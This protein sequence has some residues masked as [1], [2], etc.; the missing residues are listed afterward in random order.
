MARGQHLRCAEYRAAAVEVRFCRDA[1]E[2][3]HLPRSR[4]SMIGEPPTIAARARREC[5]RCRSAAGLRAAGGRGALRTFVE[6][7]PR[8]PAG[9]RPGGRR[10]HEHEAKR[11]ERERRTSAQPASPAPL[12][13]DAPEPNRIG[14][15]SSAGSP[16]LVIFG[17]RD[18]RSSPRPYQG[19]RQRKPVPEGSCRRL[20]RVDVD[21]EVHARVGARRPPRAARPHRRPARPARRSRAFTT[22]TWRS[23]PRR[24]NRAP[25]RARRRRRDRALADCGRRRRRAGALRRS[26]AALAHRGAAA[27]PAAR[28]P[29]TRSGSGARTAGS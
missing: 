10:E 22:S 24:R 19:G 17:P 8:R 6:N 16:H 3:E 23:R 2:H 14:R 9:A 1:R 28:R 21:A 7:D 5:V 27:R 26:P 29:S 13:L 20:L 11:Y 25:G 12:H 4:R 18:R 15:L